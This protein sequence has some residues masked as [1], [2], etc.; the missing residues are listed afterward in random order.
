M[1]KGRISAKVNRFGQ[2]TTEH[3][4]P[5]TRED[6]KILMVKGTFNG[7]NAVQEVVDGKSERTYVAQLVVDP[8]HLR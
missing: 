6:R 5:M 1:F 3:I 8:K 7:A 2:E 4:R